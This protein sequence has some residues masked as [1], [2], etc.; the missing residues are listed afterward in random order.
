MFKPYRNV[1]ASHSSGLMCVI[2]NNDPKFPTPYHVPAFWVPT[3]SLPSEFKGNLELLRC[4]LKDVVSVYHK[5]AAS[6]ASVYVDIV[7][8]GPHHNKDTVESSNS[9]NGTFV[10]DQSSAIIS[11]SVPWNSRYN[12]Y[13]KP[14][15][16]FTCILSG[17][18]YSLFPTGMKMNSNYSAHDPWVS[19]KPHQSLHKSN[20]VERV[21]SQKANS[22]IVYAC[23][24]SSK[25]IDSKHSLL[26][27]R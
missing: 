16:S 4:Q 5:L 6:D 11:F 13:G 23:V 2:K 9:D 1:T 17:H 12:G 21:Y 24:A 27:T 19:Y 14:T 22:P 18:L 25:V 10:H 20:I 7:R 8:K 26:S 15:L 3:D